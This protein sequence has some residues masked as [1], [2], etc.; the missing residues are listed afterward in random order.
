M[1]PTDFQNS[2]WYA[3]QQIPAGKLRSYGEVAED[4]DS[5]ARAVGGALGYLRRHPLREAV[6][7]WWRVVKSGKVGL[8]LYPIDDRT[9][10]QARL[11]VLEGHLVQLVGDRYVVSPH[12]SR[13][14]AEVLFRDYGSPKAPGE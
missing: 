2:V 1:D 5:S 11:L 6:V 10:E 14:V 4:F 7:P 12:L 8:Y 3:V 9:Q 13:D